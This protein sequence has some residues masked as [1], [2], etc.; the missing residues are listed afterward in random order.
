MY[1]ATILFV[2]IIITSIGILVKE[3]ID[4]INNGG[5]FKEM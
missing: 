1:T 2:I 3:M 4:R 5:K